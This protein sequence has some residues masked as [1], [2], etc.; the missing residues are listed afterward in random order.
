M[1]DMFQIKPGE[2]VAI[3][4]DLTSDRTIVDALASATMAAGALP[5]IM[6][7][8]KA[9]KESQAGMQYWP[10][11]ALTAAL[12]K[13]DVWIEANSMVILYSDIWETAMR[14]NKKL[15]YLII[16]DSTIESLDRVFTG[17]DIPTLKM[18]LSKVKDIVMSSKKVRITSD[19]GT[20]ISY[21]IDLNYMFDI[22]DGDY[23]QPKFG[24]APGFVNI[25]PKLA[26]MN[27][28][29]V[30]DILQ[31]SE[32]TSKLEFTMKNGAIVDVIGE[33]GAEAFK[34]YLASFND[35]N[36]YKISHNMLGFN[37]GVRKLTR[38]LVEDERIWGGVDF[39]FG[40]TSA[41]D[42]PPLGQVAK[43]H[44]DGVVEN[45]SIYLDDV[46]ITNKGAVCHPELKELAAKLLNN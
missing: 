5:L 41:M 38:E 43:S 14:E 2:T 45:T 12:C 28:N 21:D 37:P 11:E 36:M 39:G 9:E 27:G 7:V 18:L 10:S 32:T 15:R 40:H 26:S 44:F 20:D 34:A 1:E 46:Q 17:F 33:K 35:E 29:I 3:T 4:I 31:N 22:D 30:F 42:M 6:V 25:V 16:S 19:N 8:P 13:A 23:S 24:T